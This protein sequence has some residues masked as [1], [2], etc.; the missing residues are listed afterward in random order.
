MYGWIRRIEKQHSLWLYYQ[1]T[2]KP[3]EARLVMDDVLRKCETQ[4]EGPFP[5][6][7]Q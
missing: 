3:T 1:N 4:Q 7:P 2:K 6:V 5:E